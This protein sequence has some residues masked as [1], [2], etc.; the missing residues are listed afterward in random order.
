MLVGL[1]PGC[2]C[3]GLDP[4]SMGDNSMVGQDGSLNS[5]DSAWSLGLWE[6]CLKVEFVGASLEA[7]TTTVS[8]ELGRPETLVYRIPTAWKRRSWKPGL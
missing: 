3:L 7:K 5:Q 2:M 6:D 4:G 1:G 8:L